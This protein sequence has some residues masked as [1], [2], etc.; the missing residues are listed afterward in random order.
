MTVDTLVT[1]FYCGKDKLRAEFSDEHIWPDA[2]GG[3]H[4]SGFWRTDDVCASCNSMS[5]IFVDGGFIRGWAGS[6]ERSMDVRQY[7]SLTEPLKTVLP[8]NY[9][10]RLTHDAIQPDEVAEWWVGPC[11]ATIVHFRP[12]ETEEIWTSY[13][14]GDPRAKKKC[15]GRAY[16]ALASQSEYWIIGALGAFEKHFRRAKRYVVNMDVPVKWKSFSQ[17]DRNDPVQAADLKVIDMILVAAKA[18]TSVRTQ[19]QLRIDTDTRFLCKLGLAI[20]CKL[21]GAD[22]GTHPA[23]A[24]LRKAFRE[25]DFVRRQH[26]PIRGLGYFNGPQESPLGILSWPAAWVLIVTRVD[27]VLGL[28]VV[29]PSEKH[30][31]IR[32][33]DDFLLVDS[34]GPEYADGLVWI[35]IPPLDRAVGPI[36]MTDYVAHVIGEILHPGLSA[37]AAPC[38]DPTTLPVCC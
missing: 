29:T 5:G 18:H 23:G 28:S 15:A 33:T 9:L 36:P 8:L 27:G 11:G 6:A 14:G 38:I 24:Q 1:C 32:I 37:L 34:L 26:I 16:I 10:G 17:I 22:F 4:L 3:D 2:L 31:A 21:F 30:M 13:L 20:G 25:P 19:Q 7:L 12:A 35:T